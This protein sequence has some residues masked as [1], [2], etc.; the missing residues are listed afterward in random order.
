M[1]MFKSLFSLVQITIQVLSLLR[2]DAF[3]KS[4]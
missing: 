2:T 3:P 4:N 1:A